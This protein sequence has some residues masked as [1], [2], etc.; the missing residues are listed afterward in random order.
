MAEAK[1][2]DPPE[3]SLAVQLAAREIEER[4]K[5]RPCCERVGNGAWCQLTDGHEGPHAS[6]VVEFGPI[7]PVR[8]PMRMGARSLAIAADAAERGQTLDIDGD[9]DLGGEG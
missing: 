2:P 4:K 7:A 6:T 3:L 5:L 1:N 9:F 8:L